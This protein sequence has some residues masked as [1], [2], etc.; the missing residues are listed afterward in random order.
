MK[1]LIVEDDRILSGNICESLKHMFETTQAY[2]GLEGLE[3]ID[4][5]DYDVIVLDVMMPKMDGLALLKEIRNSGNTTPVLM[6]TALEQVSDKV[7]GLRTGADDY[8][9]KPFDIDELRARLEALV[10]RSTPG[11]AG[12]TLNFLELEIN[13]SARTARIGEHPLSLPGKQFDLLEYMVSNKNILVHRDRIFQRVWG[14]YSSTSFSV[15][16]VY[17]SQLRKE[18]KKYGY[19]KYLKT[20]HS[21]GYI[22]TDDVDLH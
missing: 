1:A 7:R 10:R 15:I 20:V 8:L 12:N 14:Y 9:V 22:F 16:D 13:L 5:G 3:S 2:D 17:L 19:D 18:L 21:M 4:H 11:Y 6:L